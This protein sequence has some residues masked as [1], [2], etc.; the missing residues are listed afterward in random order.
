[1]ESL[2]RRDSATGNPGLHRQLISFPRN[3]MTES[4]LSA[5]ADGVALFREDEKGGWF[6]GATRI[7]V[8]VVDW[9]L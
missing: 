5:R 7:N 9:V 2:P 3:E 4:V 6:C 1:M 8:Q